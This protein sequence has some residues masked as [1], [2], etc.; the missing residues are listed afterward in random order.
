MSMCIKVS[1]QSPYSIFGDNSKMLEAKS[2]YVPS[3]Y[4]VGIQ[5]KK[6]SFFY[7][8]FDLN[9]GI[10]TLTDKDGNMILQD[11][12]SEN[13]KAMFTTIDPYAENY[14]NLSP[15]AYC[16]GNPVKFIDPD[17]RN[18]IY[19]TQGNFLGTDNTGLQGFYFVMDKKFFVQGM[20]NMEAGNHAILG[21]IP[22]NVESRINNHYNKLPN[23]P[24]YDGFVT[25]SEGIAWAKSHPNALKNPTPD[26]MLYIDAS[27]LDFW[28]LSTS[29][30]TKVDLITPKNLFS[31]HNI[32]ESIANPI[33]MATVYALGRVDMIL[34]NRAEGKVKIVNN[35]ATDY[36]WNVGGGSKRNAFIRTNNVLF[37]INL[38][39][40]GFKT[41]YYG[42]GTLRR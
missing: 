42:V 20:S 15:Y 39:I 1:A 2:E 7:A 12:I 10:A 36:D 38:D 5:T 22:S 34:T 9:R 21:T 17:G 11:V 33:L 25:V 41:F 3:I 31:N 14:Y 8:D 37:G 32:A 26:N 29:D 35:S 16:F 13:A 23:R 27:Q 40:H 18:P 4:R 6:G 28:D 24:D 19:D 30:F